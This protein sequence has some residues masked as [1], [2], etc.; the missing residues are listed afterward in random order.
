SPGRGGGAAPARLMLFPRP[1]PGPAK[2][3]DLRH[4]AQ[5]ELL[6]ADGADVQARRELDPRGALRVHAAAAQVREQRL[7]LLAAGDEADV[8][9]IARRRRLE[10]ALVV[11][12]HRRDDDEAVRADAPRR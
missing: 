4:D 8:A 10:R 6:R 11:L 7:A 12:A 1:G 3:N 5:R 2:L 9:C